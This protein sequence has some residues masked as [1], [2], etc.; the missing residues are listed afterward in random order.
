[1]PD[2]FLSICSC[3]FVSYTILLSVSNPSVLTRGSSECCLASLYQ[4]LWI[5]SYVF[6]TLFDKW[7]LFI[8]VCTQFITHVTES[9]NWPK[10][11]FCFWH[12]EFIQFH[13]FC[14]SAY[15]SNRTLS[16]YIV[17]SFVLPVKS[18]SGKITI[19]SYTIG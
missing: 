3:S 18:K 15:P 5:K 19:W 8:S 14:C 9:V 2:S 12:V 13:E 4:R 6:I 17:S 1:M 16:K 7:E 10:L 11:S